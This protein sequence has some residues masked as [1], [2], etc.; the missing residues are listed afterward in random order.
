MEDG[1]ALLDYLDV[2]APPS[3]RLDG[4]ERIRRF[5]QSPESK[6]RFEQEARVL[7]KLLD[8]DAGLYVVDVRDPILGKHKD[9]LSIL[10][11]CGH[12]LLPV[13]NFTSRSEER[14][15]GKACVSTC[16]SRWSPC[17]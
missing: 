3:E 4:H 14:R 10:A 13:L 17:H 1:I 16:R 9:E 7:Q 6:R 8:C 2:L 12:P 5:L 11:S 15:V